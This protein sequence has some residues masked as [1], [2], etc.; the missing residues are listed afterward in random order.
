MPLLLL[1][2]RMVAASCVLKSTK[3]ADPM[4]TIV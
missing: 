4:T 2:A 3:A 1:L